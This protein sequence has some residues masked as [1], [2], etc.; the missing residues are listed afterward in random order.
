M[1]SLLSSTRHIVKDHCREGKKQKHD[2]S[3]APPLSVSGERN[4][5]GEVNIASYRKHPMQLPANTKQKRTIYLSIPA[6]TSQISKCKPPVTYPEA[7]RIRQSHPP[8][9]PNARAHGPIPNT[10]HLTSSHPP[11]PHQKVQYSST[12]HSNPKNRSPEIKRVSALLSINL[13]HN[14]QLTCP[15]LQPQNKTLTARLFST[16]SRPSHPKP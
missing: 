12:I 13:L 7:D 14:P 11:Q 1:I 8:I 9:H 2:L 5:H 4:S 6:P 16:P 3:T 15:N 10:Q